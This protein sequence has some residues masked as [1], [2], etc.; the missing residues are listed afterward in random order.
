MQTLLPS[1]QPFVDGDHLIHGYFLPREYSVILPGVA[2]LILLLLVGKQAIHQYNVSRISSSKCY[3]Y[4]QPLLNS[5]DNHTFQEVAEDTHLLQA[6]NHLT[7]LNHA[8]IHKALIFLLYIT[9][10]LTCSY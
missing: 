1:F 8:R 6:L 2:A 4:I 9:V 10:F 5:C 7:P 3:K